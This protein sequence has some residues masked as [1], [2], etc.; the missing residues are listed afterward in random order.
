M[1]NGLDDSLPNLQG[2]NNSKVMIEPVKV[3][4]RV[5]NEEYG[6]WMIVKRR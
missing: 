1:G 5:E 3:Q 6:D 4:D 2:M